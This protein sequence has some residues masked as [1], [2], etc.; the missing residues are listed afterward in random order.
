MDIEE[1]EKDVDTYIEKTISRLKVLDKELRAIRLGGDDFHLIIMA[2]IN[3]NGL[4]A[5][6]DGL[7]EEM[8]S[9]LF[10]VEDIITSMLDELMKI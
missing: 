7:Y 4:T 1:L 2:D 8:Q 6:K 10:V 9:K 3:E 5:E